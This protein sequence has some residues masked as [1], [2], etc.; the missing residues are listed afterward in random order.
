M[1]ND[2]LEKQVLSK[3]RA[4][5][6]KENFVP[7]NILDLYKV[8]G[9]LPGETI[10]KAFVRQERDRERAKFE[11]ARTH[12]KASERALHHNKFAAL[13]PKVFNSVEVPRD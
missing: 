13:Y 10:E 12:A 6:Y 4:E 3:M 1:G 9:I 2:E 8:G 7:A 5:G 11:E